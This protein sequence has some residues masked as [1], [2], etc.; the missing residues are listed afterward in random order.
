[1][2][3]VSDSF[4]KCCFYWIKYVHTTSILRVKFMISAERIVTMAMNLELSPFF[5]VTCDHFQP[6]N[7][8]MVNSTNQSAH[9]PKWKCTLHNS[10]KCL[11]SHWGKV[12]VLVFQSFGNGS[13]DRVVWQMSQLVN[14]F[15]LVI[16]DW[17][18]V[19][20]LQSTAYFTLNLIIERWTRII[21]RISKIYKMKPCYIRIATTKTLHNKRQPQNTYV[22][23]A[24]NEIERN[25]REKKFLG[26][27]H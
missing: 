17:I 12:I 23:N 5:P 14:E 24:W 27:F 16:S 26:R 3:R 2:A 10:W 9:E 18:I 20:L 22:W 1:M 6:I 4:H 13:I 7:W 25:E 21:V 19:F 11:F 8:V 15:Y